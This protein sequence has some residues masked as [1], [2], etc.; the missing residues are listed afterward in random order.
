MTPT[1]EQ[2]AALQEFARM[3]GPTWKSCLRSAWGGGYLKKEKHL[4]PYLQQIRN[5]LG[6]EWLSKFKL[7]S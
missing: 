4:A 7:N 5:Q 6:P 1:P 2:L 3:Y